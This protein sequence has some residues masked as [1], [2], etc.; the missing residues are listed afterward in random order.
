ME[1]A[2]L[3]AKMKN[4]AHTTENALVE[5]DI[6]PWEEDVFKFAPI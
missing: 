2:E 5:M 4:T 3:V 1:P 6:P